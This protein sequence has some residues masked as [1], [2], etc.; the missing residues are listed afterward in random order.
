MNVPRNLKDTNLLSLPDGRSL[1]YAEY[2]D[3]EGL[4]II[5]FHGNHNSRLMYGA[6]PGSPFRRNLHLI[7]PDRPGFGLSDFYMPG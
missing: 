1:S 3:R 5:L 2:G 4:P 6:M 7:V